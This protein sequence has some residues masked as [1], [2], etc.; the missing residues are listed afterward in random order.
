MN[1]ISISIRLAILNYYCKLL[2]RYNL[3]SKRGKLSNE[4]LLSVL[5]E[6][7]PNGLTYQEAVQLCIIFF[8]ILVPKLPM[9]ALTK[10]ELGEIFVFFIDRNFISFSQED[11]GYI[12]EKLKL[13]TSDVHDTEHWI[14]VCTSILRVGKSVVDPVIENRLNNRLGLK[15]MPC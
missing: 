12:S 1:K 15:S 2:Y 8:C 4:K 5:R 9:F 7:F 11:I 13:H 6:F 3:F 14:G 10:E